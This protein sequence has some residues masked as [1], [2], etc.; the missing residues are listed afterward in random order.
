MNSWTTKYPIMKVELKGRFAGSP[1]QIG[2]GAGHEISKMSP[3]KNNSSFPTKLRFW[4]LWNL[5][6]QKNQKL[7]KSIVGARRYSSS[8]SIGETKDLS[9]WRRLPKTQKDL[10][11]LFGYF[12]SNFNELDISYYWADFN[13]FWFF[14]KFRFQKAQ[15][16]KF[17]G[18]TRI[19]ATR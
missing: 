1:N 2:R 18:K 9:F 7:W 4:A 3:W 12:P 13:N 6:F 11:V 17:C 5:K 10:G 8:K 16:T 15:K 19:T 14:W